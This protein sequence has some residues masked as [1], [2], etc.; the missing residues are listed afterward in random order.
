MELQVPAFVNDAAR[1][2]ARQ[3]RDVV[4]VEGVGLL[5]EEIIQA[6]LKFG[7]RGDLVADVDVDFAVA[8]AAVNIV[9]VERIGAENAQL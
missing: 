3:S 5:V 4:V 1:R 6:E 8:L 9:R 7:A 2:L